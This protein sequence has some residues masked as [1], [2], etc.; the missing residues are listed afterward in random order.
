MS[1]VLV[2]GASGFIGRCLVAELVAQGHAVT[3]LVRPTSNRAA[4]EQLDVDFAVG[5][6]N[7]ADTLRAPAS[8]AEVVYHL[9]AMLK[10]PWRS[11]FLSTN[12]DGTRRVAEACAA[13][14]NPPALVFV[15]SLAAAGPS[16]DGEPRR[17]VDEPTPVSLYGRSK[18]AAE[19]AARELA[20]R[21]PIT[22]VRPP[23]VIGNGDRTSFPL[24][25]MAARG[26]AVTPTLATNRVSLVHVDDLAA[27]LIVAGEKGERMQPADVAP[28]PGTGVYFLAAPEQPTVA[29]LGRMVGRGFGRSVLVVRTPSLLT[30]VAGA[31]GHAVA[32][33]RDTP[34]ML[35]LDKTRELIAGSWI[36]S[37]DKA[38]EDLG[39]APRVSAQTR[40]QETADW[41]RGAG[42]V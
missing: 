25:R 6:V 42:W 16:R 4:L 34:S 31:L 5:D 7:D 11:D 38:R 12:A 1:R 41:Y 13:A 33:V 23:M 32:R 40:I 10:A 19:S 17:E 37:V 26:I 36:C 15:S 8:H 2:T 18:L 39:F 30:R 9:A 22:V 35:N 28:T 24:F 3:C 27:G 21:V 14:S 20:D 29:E